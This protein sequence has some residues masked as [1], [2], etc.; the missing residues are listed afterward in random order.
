MGPFTKIIPPTDPAANQDAFEEFAPEPGTKTD[1]RDD[2]DWFN[3][4]PDEQPAPRRT[5]ASSPRSSSWFQL[6]E[7]LKDDSN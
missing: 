2:Q 6:S 1:T 5:R 7:S 3:E 4:F